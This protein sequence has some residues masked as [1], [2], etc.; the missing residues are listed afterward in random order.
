MNEL[1]FLFIGL[2]IGGFSG[3]VIMCMFQVSKLSKD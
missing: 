1:A 3:I 2:I